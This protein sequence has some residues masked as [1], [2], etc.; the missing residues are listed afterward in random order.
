LFSGL[1]KKNHVTGRNM[2]IQF[3]HQVKN[4]CFG[5]EAIFG[6]MRLDHFMLFSSVAALL[7]SPGLG[8]PK[9]GGLQEATGE[10]RLK[11]L[12]LSLQGRE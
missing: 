7:G 9:M 8:V 4:R 12:E 5:S 3:T 6:A 10:I 11:I 1:K 2:V